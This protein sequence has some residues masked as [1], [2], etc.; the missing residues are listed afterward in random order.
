MLIPLPD[1]EMQGRLFTK[2][3]TLTAKITEAHECYRQMEQEADAMLHSAFARIVESAP[4][5]RMVDVAPLVRRQVERVGRDR[6]QERGERQ[7][8]GG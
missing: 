2:L 4:L 1:C 6:G 3:D 7:R 5:H 8:A